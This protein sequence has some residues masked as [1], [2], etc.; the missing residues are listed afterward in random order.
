[1][2]T[3]SNIAP[4]E[5]ESYLFKQ[6]LDA[7][8]LELNTLMESITTSTQDLKSSTQSL[9][10]NTTKVF[11]H[12]KTLETLSHSLGENIQSSVMNAAETMGDKLAHTTLEFI[13]THLIDTMN[14]LNQEIKSTTHELQAVKSLHQAK[15]LRSSVKSYLIYGSM[16]LVL[17]CVGSILGLKLFMSWSIPGYQAYYEYGR[18]WK[19][20]FDPLSDQDKKKIFDILKK[21]T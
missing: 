2:T 9:Q 13:R 19:Q 17:S 18:T 7:A 21:R 10:I 15:T 16:A 1:M 6:Q 12:F 14:G 11:A 4:M 20:A 3:S 5:Q 8:I